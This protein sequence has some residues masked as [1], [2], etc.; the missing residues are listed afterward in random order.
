MQVFVA[1]AYGEVLSV[2][3]SRRTDATVDIESVASSAHSLGLQFSRSRRQP[4]SS[5][6][7]RYSRQFPFPNNDLSI[8][9][10]EVSVGIAARHQNTP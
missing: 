1:T 10:C 9:H 6:C 5:T 2:H 7:L 3:N 8:D 4:V